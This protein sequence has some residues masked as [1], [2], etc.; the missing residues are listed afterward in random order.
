MKNQTLL[1]VM[2]EDVPCDDIRS[3]LA[4]AQTRHVRVVCLILSMLPQQP[5]NAYGYFPYDGGAIA[6]QWS[7][8]VEETRAALEDARSRVENQLI[9]A[10]VAGDVQA[11][12]CSLSD[13]STLI[14]PRALLAN[15][16]LISSNLR[17]QDPQLFRA[18]AHAILFHSPAGLF[19]NKSEVKPPYKVFVAWNGELPS[20]RAIQKAAPYLKSAD[21]VI[22]GLIDPNFAADKNGEDPG[23]D[24]ARWLSH[25][26]CRVTVQQYPSGGASV[27]SVLSRRAKE[28]GADLLV[29]GAYG[30]SK[31]REVVFGGTTQSMLEETELPIM[32]TH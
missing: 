22:V 2:S 13:I 30:R 4:D 31:M 17:Q 18:I 9:E 26:G 19:L 28:A 7:K 14:P 1:F 11:I 32:M 27:A 8:T 5:V 3:I 21:E 15:F 23:S 24:L 25:Q 16:A 20:A 6:R 10:G 29:M 12:H